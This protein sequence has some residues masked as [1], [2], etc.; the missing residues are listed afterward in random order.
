MRIPWELSVIFFQL[1]AHSV[2]T[3]LRFVE[4]CFGECGL[5]PIGLES[6]GTKKALCS[7][8]ASECIVP[9]L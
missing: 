9:T 6:E 3:L 1:H 5:R 4:I 2:G 8:D 7:A